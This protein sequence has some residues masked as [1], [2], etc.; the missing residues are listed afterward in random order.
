MVIVSWVVPSQFP[1][2]SERNLKRS[3]KSMV[4]DVAFQEGLTFY[5]A[6]YVISA[7]KAA[8][9][10]VTGDTQLAGKVKKY[11]S[12]LSSKSFSA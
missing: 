9:A 3:C 7:K 6:C 12:V 5:D 11:V 2:R 1:L 8:L 10:L 4:Y